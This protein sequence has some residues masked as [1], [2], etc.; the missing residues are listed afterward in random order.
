M[1][2]AQIAGDFLGLHHGGAPLGQRGLLA[3][4][5]RERVELVDGMAQPVGLALG[6]LDL[7]ALRIEPP[8]ARRA[9]LCQQLFRPLQPGFRARR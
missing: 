2:V 3:G 8:R 5:R 7:G 9:A 1:G 6:A 4:S